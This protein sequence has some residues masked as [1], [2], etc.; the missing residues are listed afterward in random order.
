[1]LQEQAAVPRDH[2]SVVS[3]DACRE[4]QQKTVRYMQNKVEPC[5]S[6]VA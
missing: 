5:V 6:A 2:N 3:M 4:K 1:M